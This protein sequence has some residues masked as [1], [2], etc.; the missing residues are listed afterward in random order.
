MGGVTH[1]F[2]WHF[3]DSNGVM[4][5]CGSHGAISK[6]TFSYKMNN[7]PKLNFEIVG[8]A[9]ELRWSYFYH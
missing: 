1:F 8:V 3:Q 7:P 9:I 2:Q 5:S 4:A 6:A